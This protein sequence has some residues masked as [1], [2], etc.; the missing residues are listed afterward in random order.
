MSIIRA[1][2]HAIFQILK[3]IDLLQ[4]KTHLLWPAMHANGVYEEY[5]WYRRSWVVNHKWVE[6]PHDLNLIYIIQSNPRVLERYYP[7]KECLSKKLKNK[8]RKKSHIKL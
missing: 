1:S 7:W 6:I 2:K 5:Q 8:C 3:R 4:E